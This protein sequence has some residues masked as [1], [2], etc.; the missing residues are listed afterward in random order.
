MIPAC[1][2]TAYRAGQNAADK[3]WRGA[4]TD[5]PVGGPTAGVDDPPRTDRTRCEALRPRIA[6]TL[7]L[8]D[9]LA[10]PACRGSKRIV[11]YRVACASRT[12]FGFGQAIGEGFVPGSA[13]LGTDRWSRRQF[14]HITD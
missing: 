11:P 9:R 10:A 3:G 8:A 7:R 2:S 14:Q 12:I 13:W 5:R 1:L 4:K 6:G